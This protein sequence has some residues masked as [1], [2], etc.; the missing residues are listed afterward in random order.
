MFDCATPRTASDEDRK[1]TDAS[2]IEGSSKSSE[3]LGLAAR[4]DRPS[5]KKRWNFG[6][7]KSPAAALTKQRPRAV[8]ERRTPSS[9]RERLRPPRH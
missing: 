3:V 7:I 8:H 1:Q 5:A 6:S 4:P 2:T 9:V